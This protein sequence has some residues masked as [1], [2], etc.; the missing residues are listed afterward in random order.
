MFREVMNRQRRKKTPS[1]GNSTICRA[2][3]SACADGGIWRRAEPGPMLP[4]PQRS[5]YRRLRMKT[6]VKAAFVVMK[7]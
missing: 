7:S 6:G 3:P 4:A 2:L 5:N 1:A